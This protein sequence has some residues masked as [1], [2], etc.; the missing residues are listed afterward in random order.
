[1]ANTH[2]NPYPGLR[3]FRP[4]EEHLF[5]GRELQVDK[6]LSKLMTRRFLA[7]VG[8]SGSGKSS[9]VNCGLRPALHR[10]YLASAGAHWR[11]AQFR[12]GSDPIRALT[13][14]LAAPGLLFVK[15][16]D[17]FLTP[18]EMIDSTLRLGSL[19]LVQCVEQAQLPQDTQLLIVVD[20]FEEL[21]RYGAEQKGQKLGA[22]NSEKTA[23]IKLL[24]EAVAQPDVPIHVVITM[25]S[26]FLGDCTQ[27]EGLPEAINDGQ[28][29]VP[30]L[31]RQQIRAAITN[32]AQVRG[33]VISPVLTTRLLNELGDNAD[34][35]SILQ[36]A[37]NRTWAH[38][39]TEGFGQGAIDLP[40]YEAIGGLKHALDLHAEKAFG[41]LPDDKAKRLCERIFKALTDTGTDA[42][43]TRRITPIGE[44]A[45]VTN[46]TVP[47]II[48]VAK[49]FRKASRSFLMPPEGEDIRDDSDI[50][51]SHESLMRL[52]KRLRLWTR[53]EA[54]S[55][56]VFRNL[57][58]TALRHQKG[59]AS[60]LRGPELSNALTWRDRNQPTET[61]SR[62]YGGDFDVAMDFLHQSNEAVRSERSR[63]RGRKRARYAFAALLL[64][65]LAPMAAVLLGHELREQ[66]AAAREANLFIDDLKQFDDFYR[67]RTPFDSTEEFCDHHIGP[68][69]GDPG[70]PLWS[71]VSRLALLEDFCIDRAGY[72]DTSG[73]DRLVQFAALVYQG[74]LANVSSALKQLPSNMDWPAYQLLGRLSDLQ[75]PGLVDERNCLVEMVG[76]PGRGDHG[77]HTIKEMCE[78]VDFQHP[79]H[80]PIYKL[81]GPYHFDHGG[82]EQRIARLNADQRYL[83]NAYGAFQVK[84]DGKVYSD[85]HWIY[86]RLGRPIEE[87]SSFAEAKTMAENYMGVALMF[88]FWPIWYVWRWWGRRK[89]RQYEATPGSHRRLAATLFDGA[90]GV[91]AGFSIFASL[92]FVALMRNATGLMSMSAAILVFLAYLLY[93]DALRFRYCRSLGKIAF[94][95]RPLMVDKAAQR[96]ITFGDSARRN[97]PKVLAIIVCAMFSA[98]LYDTFSFAGMD[99]EWLLSTLPLFSGALALYLII[100]VVAWIE[101]RI[102]QRPPEARPS[103]KWFAGVMVG[104][105]SLVIGLTILG[106]PDLFVGEVVL[107]ILVWAMMTLPYIV[108]LFRPGK[109]AR[110]RVVDDESDASGRADMLPAYVPSRSGVTVPTGQTA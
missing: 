57:R 36:H 18:E 87:N 35:L 24:L 94:D 14:A 66:F 32:P 48:E 41:E 76:G 65:L 55:A 6:M 50:D 53:E 69:Y 91:V 7:V 75:T 44:L 13:R 11:M 10:G 108:G 22:L 46:A 27:F 61:W 29:L 31:T 25:R 99:Q 101:R 30:R 9:L 62:R 110:S 19:G 96:Q 20:Q 52:W 45:Q 56:R 70:Q 39:E 95:L 102:D 16:E 72:Y 89:G 49:V 93:C 1:M 34:Q 77:N 64:V 78:N 63:Q 21:F 23:F 80:R 4:D 26:D 98:I 90:I 103:P 88:L 38:W 81:I 109:L 79:L 12:P 47:E 37:L 15:D 40:D 43:G 5:F 100:L 74:D 85:M 84:D 17:S 105:L 33:E 83:L 3:P 68:S 107:L 82:I 8:G 104:L 67:G 2:R 59:E 28:Y 97:A 51:I 73:K 106:T 54:A 71:S 60:H 42:R 86:T 58:E 92:E